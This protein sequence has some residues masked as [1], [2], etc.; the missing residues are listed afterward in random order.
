[1]NSTAAA[2]QADQ[3]PSETTDCY[4]A[5]SLPSNEEQRLKALHAY[6][7][8]ETQTRYVDQLERQQ[9]ELEQENAIDPLTGLGSRRAFE[10]RLH[11]ELWRRDSMGS[12]VALMI[13]DVDFFK[14][15]NDCRAYDFAARVGGEEFAVILPGTTRE[16]AFVI[17]ERMR[18]SVHREVWPNRPVTISAGVAFASVGQGGAAQLMED[19]DIALYRSKRDG[20]NRV[21]LADQGL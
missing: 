4:L 6:G 14:R 18:R 15:Y 8:L 2:I 11:V 9:H 10:E 17:A 3:D 5:A 20:R 7:V 13:L 12:S 19:A 1:M 16:S 21:T